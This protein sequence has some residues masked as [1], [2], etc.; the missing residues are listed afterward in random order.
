MK[1][2]F[3]VIAATGLFCAGHVSAQSSNYLIK[4]KITGASTGKVYLEHEDESKKVLRDS[5]AL[6]AN[7]DFQFKGKVKSPQFYTIKLKASK[8]TSTFILENSVV[9]FVAPKDSLYKAAITG[10]K[11]HDVY[12]GFYN[13]PWKSITVKAGDIYQRLDKAEQGG[14]VKLDSMARSGFDREFRVLDTLNQAAVK[15]YVSLHP[16][17]V[18]S[19]A[20]I[21]DRFIA[22]PDF[23]VAKSLFLIL[24]PQVQKSLIG[25]QITHA[26]KLDDKTAPGQIAPAIAM[27][28]KDGKIVHLSDFKGKYVMVDFWASWCGPCRKEN[29]N[30]VAA[31]KK[32]HDKGFEVLGVSLDSNKESWLKAI[33]ADGLTWTHVSDLKGWANAAA[34]EYGVKA[35]P[36]SFLIGP[37]GKVVGR[38]LRGEALNKKLAELMK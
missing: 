5:T 2:K 4:G 19:A 33:T 20:I 27:A 7:G 6:S 18:G 23:P 22:Y 21:Y 11:S 16:G 24:S 9:A 35:V 15:A 28:D 8:N 12:K 38:D 36:A 25:Q 1:F 37:D 17:S 29:P 34:A 26:F 31:Y 3:A 32:Y 13:G 14:K 30:V 10:S